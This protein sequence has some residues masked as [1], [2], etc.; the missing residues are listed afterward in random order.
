MVDAST[1]LL[2]ASLL[3]CYLYW[4]VAL[5][6]MRAAQFSAKP[7]A[8]PSDKDSAPATVAFDNKDQTASKAG[9][10]GWG[11][12]AML[13]MNNHAE[14]LPQFGLAALLNVAVR[15]GVTP[16]AVSGVM[17]GVAVFRGAHLACYLADLDGLRSLSFLG[18][19][20]L[21]LALYVMVFVSF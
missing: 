2:A 7:A 12:R 13:A 1:A 19:S 6:F 15:S 17:A 11:K 3:V 10:R 4:W 8:E 14:Q 16:W 21:T 9:L 20:L 5:G 18:S